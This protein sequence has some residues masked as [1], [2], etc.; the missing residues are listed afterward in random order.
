MSLVPIDQLPTDERRAARTFMAAVY[1]VH[2]EHGPQKVSV[3]GRASG[4]PDFT[5][6]TLAW[7]Q[8]WNRGLV[9]ECGKDDDGHP[10]F[11][12]VG[13]GDGMPS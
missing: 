2:G 11:R 12:P 4:L 5:T 8:C 7:I 10:L 3:Y 9:V 1:R 6:Y 13:E